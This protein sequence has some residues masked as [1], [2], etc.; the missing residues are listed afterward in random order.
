VETLDKLSKEDQKLLTE[1]SG[2]NP[3]TGGQRL[4]F[5]YQTKQQV[6]G[7]LDSL[8]IKDKKIFQNMSDDER[9][10]VFDLVN[11]RTPVKD[12]A[13]QNAKDLEEHQAADYALSQ[14]PKSASEFVEQFQMYKATLGSIQSRRIKQYEATEERIA[15]KKYGK[16]LSSLGERE[17]PLV[18]KEA[19]VEVFGKE[20]LGKNSIKKEVYIETVQNSG[21]LDNPEKVNSSTQNIVQEAYKER[22]EAFKG[23]IGSSKINLNQP[24]GENVQQVQGLNKNGELR[25]SSESA[26]VYH[27]EKHYESEF[28]PNERKTPGND[29][30][31]YLAG[32]SETVKIPDNVRINI[33]QAGNRSIAFERKIIGTNDKILKGLAIVKISPNGE[34]TLATYHIPGEWK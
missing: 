19:T 7:Y 11:E 16:P 18:R 29:V 5:E 8:K 17:L 13:Q 1:L 4:R 10:R 33:D 34:V 12:K 32:A 21:S 22:T 30:D 31:K 20:I 9:A 26:G 23:R 28:P 2:S 25:F 6:D 15:N 3:K 27:V 24:V 14:N